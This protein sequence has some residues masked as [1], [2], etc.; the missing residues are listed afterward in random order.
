MFKGTSAGR[1]RLKLQVAWF[2]CEGMLQFGR[3]FLVV[4][5]YLVVSLFNCVVMGIKFSFSF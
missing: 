4:G 3:F 2:C 1:S 5:G